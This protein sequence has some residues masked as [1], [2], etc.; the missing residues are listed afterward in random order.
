MYLFSLMKQLMFNF[1][2]FVELESRNASKINKILLCL[3]YFLTEFKIR[4]KQC[5]LVVD[6]CHL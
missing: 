5:K 6:N 1:F 4:S 2:L 3:S